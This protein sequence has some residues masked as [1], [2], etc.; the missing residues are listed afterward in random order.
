MMRGWQAGPAPVLPHFGACSDRYTGEF[1]F[2]FCLIDFLSGKPFFCEL[3]TVF[4]PRASHKM[5]PPHA[6]PDPIKAK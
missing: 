1:R 5:A 3:C 4:S 2:T 6:G